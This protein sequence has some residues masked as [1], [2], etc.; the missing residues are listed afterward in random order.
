[1]RLAGLYEFEFC[2]IVEKEIEQDMP[3]LYMLCTGLQC[4]QVWLLGK[5]TSWTTQ[6]DIYIL[7]GFWG[8]QQAGLE[9]V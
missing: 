3:L 7:P 2:L 8:L 9:P 4:V 1:M 5:Q 6:H